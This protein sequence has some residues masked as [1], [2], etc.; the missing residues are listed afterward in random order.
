MLDHHCPWLSTCI[1]GLNHKK[2]LFLIGYSILHSIF[3]CTSSVISF[4][5]MKSKMNLSYI[6]LSCLVI[7]L[8]SIALVALIVLLLLNII[9]ISKNTTS[10]EEIRRDKKLIPS[11]SERTCA[12]NW[13]QF[14]NE[15]FSY[16]NQIKYNESAE[17]LLNKIVTIAEI[18]LGVK[19]EDKEED[20][21]KN[22]LERIDNFKEKSE[23]RINIKEKE[24]LFEDRFSIS[25]NYI[26][27]KGFTV[28]L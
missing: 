24:E 7:S 11:F 10:S 15:T 26:S 21:E 13:S 5:L 20:K 8:S 28:K 9:Y 14:L 22:T 12:E 17:N 1:G 6:I 2:F 4:L 16:R 23:V 19:K 3:I 27:D 25:T 18:R